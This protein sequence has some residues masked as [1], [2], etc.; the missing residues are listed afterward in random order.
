MTEEFARRLAESSVFPPPTLPGRTEKSR[1]K[2]VESGFDDVNQ[3]L[4]CGNPVSVATGRWLHKWRMCHTGPDLGKYAKLSCSSM[5]GG[6]QDNDE[7]KLL[8]P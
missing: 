8:S 1:V 4:E 2:A 6:K 3:T 5:A 7:K